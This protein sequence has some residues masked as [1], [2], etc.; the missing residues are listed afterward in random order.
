MS[1][2]VNLKGKRFGKLLVLRR[3]GVNKWQQVTWHTR[4]DCGKRRIVVGYALYSGIRL[5]DCCWRCSHPGQGLS[6]THVPEYM[7]YSA[8]KI[9]C[10]CKT[11]VAY[12]HYGRRGIKICDRWLGPSGFVN[13]CKDMGRRPEGKT[14]DR[15]NPEGDYTPGNCRWASDKTQANNKRCS[16]SPEE[17][18]VLQQEADK[19]R[20]DYETYLAGEDEARREYVEINGDDIGF[21]H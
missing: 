3:A 2:L 15:R 18:A 10:L 9:R 21:V 11:C 17:L 1:K 5:I 6:K 13:F 12:K 14:L 8:M 16:Y 4:C 19:Q 7:S 20:R